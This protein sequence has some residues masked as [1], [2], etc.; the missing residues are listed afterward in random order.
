MPPPMV[1]GSSPASSILW[2]GSSRRLS[3]PAS[4]SWRSKDSPS[5]RTPMLL[6]SSASPK[7]SCQKSRSPFR[8]QSS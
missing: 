5:T 8:S 6:I 1:K 3:Q 2:K 4:R 7:G